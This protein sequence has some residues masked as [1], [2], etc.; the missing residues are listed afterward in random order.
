MFLRVESPCERLP[1]QACLGTGWATG[2]VAQPYRTAAGHKTQRA[3][4]EVPSYL[5][6]LDRISEPLS[7]QLRYCNAIERRQALTPGRSRRQ[8]EPE[9]RFPPGLRLDP[10]PPAVL[11]HNRL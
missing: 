10:D 5:Q 1:H 8:L 9:R 6:D 2:L 4:W 7:R 3:F 11:L